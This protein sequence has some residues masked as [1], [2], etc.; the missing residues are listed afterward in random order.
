M[1]LQFQSGSGVYPVVDSTKPLP[2]TYE[3]NKQYAASATLAAPNT[4][5][6]IIFSGSVTDILITYT[7]KDIFIAKNIESVNTPANG[8]EDARIFIP[9]NTVGLA[10]PWS[11]SSIHFIN[12]SS[13][14][15][16]RLFVVGFGV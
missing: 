5:S 3:I 10:L 16:P 2:T 9:A 11:G 4:S 1:L 6:Q 15:I 8:G 12:S 14:D 13:G 7:D